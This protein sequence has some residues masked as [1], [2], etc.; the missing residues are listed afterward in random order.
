MIQMHQISAEQS[1]VWYKTP[2]DYIRIQDKQ[3]SILILYAFCVISII[4]RD[5]QPI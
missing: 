2:K 5:C 3:G 4:F 1:V